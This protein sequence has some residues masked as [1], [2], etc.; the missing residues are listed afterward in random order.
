MVKY[1]YMV[2]NGTEVNQEKLNS[3]GEQGWLLI[4]VIAF[5]GKDTYGKKVAYLM[6]ASDYGHSYR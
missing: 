5:E 6:R 3:L 1:S 4:S 2:L